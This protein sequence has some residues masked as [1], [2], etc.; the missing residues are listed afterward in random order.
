MDLDDLSTPALILDRRRLARNI[1]AMS[2]RARA[3]GVGL[4]PHLK[5]AKSADVAR[6]VVA[7]NS[8][9]VT[10]STLHEAEYFL[11][12]GI[13]D[14]TYAV[15]MEPGRLDRTAALMD[16]GAGLK[17]ITDNAGV[18]R[19]IAGHGGA[20]QVLI[21]IDTGGGRGDHPLG[22]SIWPL[23]LSSHHGHAPGRGLGREPQAGGG[24]SGGVRG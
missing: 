6:L 4:R 8:G 10:V 18:A 1:E 17:I 23:R 13:A 3:L 19:A 14:L 12:H 2:A 15:G 21:K 9:G 7:G 5:T 20:F 16:Q 22:R 11:D 24:A